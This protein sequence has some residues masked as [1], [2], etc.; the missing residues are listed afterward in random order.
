MTSKH[1]HKYERRRLGS[2]K[3]S[4]HEIYR[5]AVPGCNHYL[6]NME[7]VI[8][9]FSQCWGKLAN[10]KDCPEEVEMTRY[11][12]NNEKRKHPLCNACKRARQ[13]KRGLKKD[14]NFLE[15]EQAREDAISKIMEDL[16]GD[17]ATEHVG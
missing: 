1:V 13:L 12:V 17:D 2:W 7:L 8:G 10:D 16:G 15:A 6:T 4:G 9:R 11:L 5:C 3:K 14:P